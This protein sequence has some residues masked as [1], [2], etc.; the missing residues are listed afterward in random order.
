[1]NTRRGLEGCGVGGVE[2]GVDCVASCDGEGEGFVVLVI[3]EPPLV[4]PYTALREHQRHYQWGFQHS[5]ETSTDLIDVGTS[6]LS[7]SGARP[8]PS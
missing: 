7:S 1:M 6:A 3:P 4:M 5:S 2:G 8:P